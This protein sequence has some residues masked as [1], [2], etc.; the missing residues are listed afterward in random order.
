MKLLFMMFLPMTP[1]KKCCSVQK[2]NSAPCSLLAEAR[3]KECKALVSGHILVEYERE[4]EREIERP[5]ICVSVNNRER[6]L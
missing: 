1:P 3:E 2:N 5:F 4:R 6:L